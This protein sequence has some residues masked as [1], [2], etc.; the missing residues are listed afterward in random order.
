MLVGVNP[1]SL[2]RWA[3]RRGIEPLRRQ[4]IGESYVTVWAYADILSAA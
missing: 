1:R 4:R 3:R 2:R